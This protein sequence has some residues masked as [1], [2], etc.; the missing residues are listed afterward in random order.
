M[1]MVSHQA[2][3]MYPEPVTLCSLLKKEVETIP[4][5]VGKEYLLP[6]IASEYH[7]VECARIM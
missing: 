4:V 3:G 5:A 6:C 1:N 2:K 7:M